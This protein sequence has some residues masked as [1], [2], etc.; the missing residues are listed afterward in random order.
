MQEEEDNI[1]K[2]IINKIR[3]QNKHRYEFRT[4]W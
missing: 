2:A 4:V 1:Y 3:E